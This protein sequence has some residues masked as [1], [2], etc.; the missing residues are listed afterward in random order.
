MLGCLDYRRFPYPWSFLHVQRA[1]LSPHRKGAV[2]LWRA[3]LLHLIY[4]HWR[5]ER[6]HW[7]EVRGFRIPFSSLSMMIQKL[8]DFKVGAGRQALLLK[9]CCSGRGRACSVTRMRKSGFERRRHCRLCR[10]FRR[11]R[12]V[13]TG[14]HFYSMSCV[15]CFTCHYCDRRRG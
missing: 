6:R 13:S 5:R 15:A 14:H 9:A 11:T 1:V 3:M 8:Y 2:E 4:C 7:A 10:H 12:I